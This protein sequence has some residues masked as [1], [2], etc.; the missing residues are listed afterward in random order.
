MLLGSDINVFT[1]HKILTV[2]TL[3]TQKVLH[4]HNKVKEFSHALHYLEGPHNILA[5]SLSML[6]FLVT[7]AQIMEGKNLIEHTVILVVK[8][9]CTS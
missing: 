1:N 8:M 9:T 2:D 5:D 7:P 3:K 4:W 6:H